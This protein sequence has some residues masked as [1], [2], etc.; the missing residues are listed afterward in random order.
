MLIILA[1]LNTSGALK[2]QI[3]N[4]TKVIKLILF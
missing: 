2:D 3:I 1:I 4:I